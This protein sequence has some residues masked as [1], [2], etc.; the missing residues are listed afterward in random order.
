MNHQDLRALGLIR[1]GAQLG[2]AL[3][4]D[5]QDAHCVFSGSSQRDAEGCAELRL[6]A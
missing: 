4:G 3:D 1:Q 6:A 5:F 2:V